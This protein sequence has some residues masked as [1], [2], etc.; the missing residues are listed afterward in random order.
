[1]KDNY[2]TDKLLKKPRKNSRRKGNKFEL[3]IAKMLNERFSTDE[4]CRTPGSGAFATIHKLPE[5]IDLSGD[6]ITPPKFKFYIE[7]KRGYNTFKISDFFNRK[8]EWSKILIR[9][10]EEAEKVRKTPLI[11]FKQDRCTILACT[12]VNA[13]VNINVSN[14][15]LYYEDWTILPL[16]NLLKCG[17]NT[18]F[19]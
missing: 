11:I 9:A 14:D 3:D 5:H 19:K 7:C 1:M 6:L 16:D 18:F 8:S 10:R 4:F 17:S 12:L 13:G 2:D 15:T